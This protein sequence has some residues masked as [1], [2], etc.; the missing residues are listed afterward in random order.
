M[1]QVIPKLFEWY[2]ALLVHMA[3]LIA[4]RAAPQEKFLCWLHFLRDEKSPS[5]IGQGYWVILQNH[6]TYLGKQD[7]NSSWI[8]QHL[9]HSHCVLAMEHTAFVAR[10]PTA[11]QSVTETTASLSR[12]RHRDPHAGAEHSPPQHTNPEPAALPQTATRKRHHAS[13]S[14]RETG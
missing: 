5:K 9:Q 6:Q 13:C 1:L 11:Q 4:A 14:L 10:H 7:I 3:Y 2:F 12:Q 8:C